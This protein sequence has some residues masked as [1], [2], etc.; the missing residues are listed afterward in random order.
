MAHPGKQTNLNPAHKMNRLKLLLPL[1]CAFALATL[2]LMAADGPTT[3][4]QFAQTRDKLLAKAGSTPLNADEQFS[5]ATSM[6]GLGQFREALIVASLG[7]GL[8]QDPVEKSLFY[9]AI[10]QCHGA[11]GFYDYAGQAA[12]EGQRLDPLSKELAALRFA[13]FTKDEDQAQVKAAEDTFKQLTGDGPPVCNP[14]ALWA[15]LKILYEGGK[16]IAEIVA[17]YDTAMAAWERLEPQVLE[18]KRNLD[19]FW[20][21]ARLASKGAAGNIRER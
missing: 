10:A 17:L 16:R 1:S 14:A 2:S 5:L 12:L 9:M 4:E 13:Y 3:A 20:S 7:L 21:N 6:L 11:R 19:T 15:V 8:T 18:V